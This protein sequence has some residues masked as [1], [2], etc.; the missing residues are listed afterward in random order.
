MRLIL[1]LLAISLIGMVMAWPNVED[2]LAPISQE[3]T[4]PR[5]VGQNELINP[6][7]ESEDDQRQPFTV[8]ANRAVQSARDPDVVILERPVADI[9][10]KDGTWLAAEAKQGAWQQNAEKLLLEG[11]V[12]LFHDQGYEVKMTKL[13]IN[14]KDQQAWSD[15]PVSGHGPAGTLEATGLQAQNTDEKLVFTGPVRLVLNRTIEGL[16]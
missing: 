5:T 7:F 14:M 8:T 3:A 10:L 16:E 4:A 6:R 15:T 13:L 12:K 2:T 11:N 9:I 1:P